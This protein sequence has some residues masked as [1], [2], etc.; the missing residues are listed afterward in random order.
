MPGETPSSE[1]SV[2]EPEGRPGVVMLALS[3]FRHSEHAI[4]LAL[5]KAA[6]GKELVVAYIAD[7]NLARYLVGT[8][9]GLFP[10]L[11]HQT[12]KA[13][14]EEDE[15]KARRKAQSI[16]DLAAER[17]IPVRIY[18]R[19]GRF[20]VECLKIVEQERPS[21]VVTTR[22]GRPGWVRRFFGSPVDKLL[23]Q[24]GCPVIEV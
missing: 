9:V 12:E 14:L 10:E 24:A 19:I 4:A 3:T 23:A 15:Q 7:V 22:S 5:D 17:D 20:A 21:L 8:D 11:K 13:I 1:P 2:I 18:A 16:A 6:E